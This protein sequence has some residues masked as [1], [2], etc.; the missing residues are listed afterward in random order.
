MQGKFENRRFSKYK[1]FLAIPRQLAAR[2]LILIFLLII[3]ASG[4]LFLN[5]SEWQAY[6]FIAFPLIVVN[7]LSLILYIYGIVIAIKNK[8]V[9]NI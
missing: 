9:P 8:F 7:L 6:I 4:S 3:A 5:L 1:I 2:Q